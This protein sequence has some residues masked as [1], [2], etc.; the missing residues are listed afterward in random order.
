MEFFGKRA[1]GLEMIAIHNK[2]GAA[3]AINDMVTGDVQV[4]FLNVASTAA[5]IKA[6]KIKPLAVVNHRRLPDY[7]DVPT[8]AEVGFPDVG[9]IAWNAMFAPAATPKPVLETLH[10]AALEALASPTGKEALTK[11]HFN[12]VPSKSVDDAKTWLAGEIGLWKKI[13]A[14]V[15]IEAE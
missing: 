7:P 13:T 1:G 6:G 8:M 4:A 11:Q 15:K 9:T 12:I 14:E 5:M 3:G 10:K 2:A